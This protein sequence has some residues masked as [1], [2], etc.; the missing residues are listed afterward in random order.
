MKI[1]ALL[2]LLFTFYSVKSQDLI[3]NI[4]EKATFI[5]AFNGAKL[6]NQISEAELEN[7][8]LFKELSY[9]MFRGKAMA[10]PS[11]I[12]DMGVNMHE[13][14]YFAFEIQEDVT[15][16][17]F[18]YKIQDISVFENFIKSGDVTNQSFG[19][20]YGLNVLTYA[21]DSK[22]Y[23]NNSVAIFIRADYDYTQ[24][25]FTYEVE[26]EKCD[27][28]KCDG[29]YS[30]KTIEMTEEQLAEI[31]RQKE[32]EKLR[33]KEMETERLRKNEELRLKNE[34]IRL[35]KEQY[36]TDKI[37]FR[38]SDFYSFTPIE[39]NQ[40]D[41][42]NENKAIYKSI[43]GIRT[44]LFNNEAVASFYYSNY[45]FLNSPSPYYYRY[46]ILSSMFGMQSYLGGNYIS[47]LFLEEDKISLK[48]KVIYSDNVKNA[49]NNIYKSKINKNLISFVSNDVLGYWSFSVNTEAFLVEME[50]ITKD[51]FEKN[52]FEYSQE[53]ELYIDLVSVMLDE[54]KIAE[55]MTGDALFVFNDINLKT[56]TYETYDYDEDFNSTKVTKTKQE[57]QPEFTVMMGSENENIIN[58]IFKL[59][60]K[61]EVLVQ[62]NSYYMLT[63]RFNETPYDLYFAFK[64][65]ILFATNSPNQVAVIVKGKA[66]TKLA[67]SHQKRIKKHVFSSYFNLNKIV[68]KMMLDENLAKEFGLL[69]E[70]K[71]D[72]MSFYAQSKVDNGVI[73]IDSYIE[74]PDGEKSSAHYLLNIIDKGIAYES[75]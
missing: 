46:G 51:Y 29:A 40:K 1:L 39:V 69:F 36:I 42:E 64:N 28:A 26:E 72:L 56:V 41:D 15:F 53:I 35:E 63:K 49:I 6:L 43:N 58:K 4:S 75:R 31:K 24:E 70:I 22:L 50:S 14:M 67:A 61:R 12:S 37:N 59:G 38:I 48:S 45:S 74:I 25:S 52:E 71:D 27:G 66:N 68:E 60:V 9:E 73:E 8:L 23:W 55:L 21:Y 34:K 5:A 32:K 2:I 11:Q 16:Y 7:S 57:L 13:K 47:D 10:K 62:K 33:Q 17:Y 44:D 3:H 18:T 30:E 54:E 20:L 65:N 19:Q